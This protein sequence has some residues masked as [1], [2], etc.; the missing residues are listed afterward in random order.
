[1][2]L[3]NRITMELP[4]IQPSN[5]D[6]RLTTIPLAMSPLKEK[7]LEYLSHTFSP[8]SQM[9]MGCHGDPRTILISS[10]ESEVTGTSNKT[11]YPDTLSHPHLRF[12]FCLMYL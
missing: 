7:L 12:Y 3:Y 10:I 4:N 2:D 9:E 11:N 8:Q 1:M 6:P 5:F